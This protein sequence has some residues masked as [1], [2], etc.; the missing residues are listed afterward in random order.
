MY[1]GDALRNEKFVVGEIF[2]LDIKSVN[3]CE[4]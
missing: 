4:E 1:N 2:F 3:I